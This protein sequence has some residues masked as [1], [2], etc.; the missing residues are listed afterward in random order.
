VSAARELGRV[1]TS[2]ISCAN[3]SGLLLEMVV[4]VVGDGRGVEVRWR[5]GGRGLFIAGAP[6]KLC[7][8]GE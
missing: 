4:D 6:I 5:G 1:L 3:M 8:K 2:A 7:Q